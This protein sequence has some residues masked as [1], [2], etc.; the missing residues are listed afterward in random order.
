MRTSHRGLLAA[1]LSLAALAACT[2]RAG[3]RAHDPT[4]PRATRRSHRSPTGRSSAPPARGTA[5]LVTARR[6]HL[7]HDPQVERHRHDDGRRR[8]PGPRVIAAR[9]ARRR[10]A[11]PAPDPGRRRRA[12]RLV[13]RRR[14]QQVDVAWIFA[15]DGGPVRAVQTVRERQSRD[16]HRLLLGRQ[17]WRA[18]RSRPARG[19]PYVNGRVT[20]AIAV[21]SSDVELLAAHA[22]PADAV[23]HFAA[24]FRKFLLP[25]DLEA[26]VL[27]GPCRTEWLEYIAATAALAAADLGV[28]EVPRQ[29][30]AHRHWSLAA[31]RATATIAEMRLWICQENAAERAWRRWPRRRGRTS[32]RSVAWSRRTRPCCDRAPEQIQ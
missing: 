4:A 10:A 20:G 22:A 30:R 15:A 19:A 8:D 12:L 9:R 21:A 13:H 2:D 11:E 5:S 1:S 27:S 18:G 28:G 7:E 16:G 14:G 25:R 29:S 17:P 24:G 3:Q 32:R 31:S 23:A 6:N 26:Q